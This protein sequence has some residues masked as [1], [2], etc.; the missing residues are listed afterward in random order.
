MRSLLLALLLLVGLAPASRA[1]P[2]A[3][4]PICL[5]RVH[6][7]AKYTVC[8]I[9]LRKHEIRLFWRA[10]DG[11]PY[12]TLSRLASAQPTGRP[13]LAAMNAGMYHADLAPVG[14]YVENGR[15]LKAANTAN[16]EG[17]FH[18]KP[19]GIFLVER[20]KAAIFET[21][22]YLKRRPKPDFAT[23]SG[24]MLV[25]DGK[26]HPKFSEEGPSKKVRNGV[27]VRDPHTVVL[28][29]SDEPVSFGAFARLF[30][31]ELGCLNALFLDGSISALYAPAL[32]RRDGLLP[33]GPML[34]VLGPAASASR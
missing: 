17:N 24:P 13:L 7:H 3:G 32:G 9:D 34:G 1:Q 20:G 21:G 15:Q 2:G 6:E 19:N 31:T 16:G 30:R 11:D 33:L 18:L 29:I 26:L 10:P 4:A 8:T 5:D 25:I 14:L 22:A 27:G 28:A 23:Q 12:G